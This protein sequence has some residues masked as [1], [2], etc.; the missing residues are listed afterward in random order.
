MTVIVKYLYVLLALVNF[1]CWAR[2]PISSQSLNDFV[3]ENRILFTADLQ[4]KPKFQH[5]DYSPL[6]SIDPVG[7]EITNQIFSLQQHIQN[8]E[9]LRKDVI[10]KFQEILAF[11]KSKNRKELELWVKMN[12]AFYLY[13]FR[14]MENAM[15]LI[16][17][18]MGEMER[19]T[20]NEFLDPGISYTLIGF[21]LQTSHDYESALFYL[22]QALRVV[23]GRE[24]L[25][26]MLYDNIGKIYF[27]LGRPKV[28][29]DYFK[30]AMSWA[31]QQNDE[32]RQAKIYG[33]QSQ[34]LM[35]RE[36]FAGAIR[37]LQKDLELSYKNGAKQNMMF[38]LTALARAY[39][40]TGQREEAT[41]SLNRALA[42]ARTNANFRSSEIQL[43]Q[44]K[45]KVA[46]ERSNVAEELEIWRR[47]DVLRD[48][49]K[50]TDGDDVIRQMR[51]Q[52]Q[53]SR[54]LAAL[55]RE[56]AMRATARI[57]IITFT[58]IISALIIIA[59][60]IIRNYRKRIRLRQVQHESTL[61]T[62]KLD[63]LL[64]EQALQQ[65]Q[66]QLKSYIRYFNEK[67]K[68]I[69]FLKKKIEELEAD[70]SEENLKRKQ[71]LYKLLES[72]L[73]TDENWF[74]FKKA[75]MMEFPNYYEYLVGNF[76]DL[77]ES[78]LRIICLVKLGL[79]SHE[80]A[81]LLGITLGAV[82]KAKGRLQKKYGNQ[83][84]QL[85]TDK[86]QG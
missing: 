10:K 4:D 26:A 66:H 54:Y 62:F 57:R 82:K 2:T 60:L 8:E 46:G 23:R 17:D 80:I 38:A 61:L 81:Q 44:L 22:K 29:A 3:V 72:H 64:S 53:K 20:F 86:P 31:V 65:T 28:A 25:A 21:Y 1:F 63:K 36:D 40:A 50:H 14:K 11:S 18:L 58:V 24:D 59:F 52:V 77:T 49:L 33:N 35:A 39:I 9:D 16:V 76:T 6:E 85:F 30:N 55:E 12:Y 67:N 5:H 42:I 75:F 37:L 56:N 70:T 83:Y 19:R 78:N 41:I 73:M 47:I 84:D 43:L 68:Q 32:V 34:V 69:E 13:H 15:P 48:S 79:S 51:W 71:E 7:W 27:D 74:E 45:V